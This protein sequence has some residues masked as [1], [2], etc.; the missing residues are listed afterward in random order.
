MKAHRYVPN[1]VLQLVIDRPRMAVPRTYLLSRR[2]SR[3][4]DL[5]G[6][7]VLVTGASSGIGA[8]TA[9]SLARRGAHVL[10]A[11]R[12]TSELDDV[13]ARIHRDG[14]SASA[15]PVDLS[16]RVA[17]ERMIG[18]VLDKHGCPDIVVNNAGRSIRRHV[19]ESTDR[20]HDFDRTLALNYLAPVQLTLGFLPAMKERGRGH[21]IN[22]STCGI[23]I[24]AMPM[25]SAYAGS[26]GAL[27]AFS[28]AVASDLRGTGVAVTLIYFP[29][30]RT[31]MIA[32]TA[33]YAEAPAI[34]PEAA[35][36]WIVHAASR[37][38]AEVIPVMA[39]FMRG[40]GALS[41]VAADWLAARGAP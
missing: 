38:G 2:R 8:A 9:A 29:L 20:L 16:D 1:P 23:P 11:S 4:D 30:V 25:F 26:K 31:A 36:D 35:A 19:L 13:V 7:S 17:T 34:T 41:P 33:D 37:R 40:L 39:S 15:W 27:T 24:G 22:V 21:F 14:G 6:Q 5:N 18:D 3:A 10:V 32:P 12:R 28:R